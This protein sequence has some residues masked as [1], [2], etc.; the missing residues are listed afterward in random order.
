MSLSIIQSWPG[1]CL[2][3]VKVKVSKCFSVSAA[4]SGWLYL[5][6]SRAP[7]ARPPRLTRSPHLGPDTRS[8]KV[9]RYNNSDN[10]STME[11]LNMEEMKQNSGASEKGY[12]FIQLIVGAVMVGVGYQYL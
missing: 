1:L 5:H 4:C 7:P 10:T 8:H 12:S 11:K 9:E 3:V 2:A 6:S